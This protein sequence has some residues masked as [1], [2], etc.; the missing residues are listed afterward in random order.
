MDMISPSFVP[1]PV[2]TFGELKTHHQKSN[3]KQNQSITHD[4]QNLKQNHNP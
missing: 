4:P 1:Q 2:I 3:K